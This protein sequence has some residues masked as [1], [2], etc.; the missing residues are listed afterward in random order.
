[1]DRFIVSCGTRAKQFIV[2]M[3]NYANFI[4]FLYILFIQQFLCTHLMLISL[5][6]FTFQF[7]LRVMS[8]EHT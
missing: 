1:M 3:A 8:I 2:Y 7:S 6:E 5:Q 4:K